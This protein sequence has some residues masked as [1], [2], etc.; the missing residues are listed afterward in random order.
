[1]IALSF[2]ERVGRDG[3]F[4]SRRG[5]GEGFVACRAS[6]G[7]YIPPKNGGTYAPPEGSCFGLGGAARVTALGTPPCLLESYGRQAEGFG[8]QGEQSVN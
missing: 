4:I 2:G 3:F 8:P 1:M 7:A 5:P 6:R